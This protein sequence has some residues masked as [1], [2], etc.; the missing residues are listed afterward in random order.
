MA[1]IDI[2]GSGNENR[3]F[4]ENFKSLRILGLARNPLV[5]LNFLLDFWFLMCIMVFS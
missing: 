4:F 1:E 3:T 2:S 5:C